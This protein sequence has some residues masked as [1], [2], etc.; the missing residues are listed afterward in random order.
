MPPQL[1]SVRAGAIARQLARSA[2]PV[3]GGAP[4]SS[5]AQ[6]CAN[7]P[8]AAINATIAAMVAYSA[9]HPNPPLPIAFHY[10]LDPNCCVFTIGDDDTANPLRLCS[11]DLGIV[12]MTASDAPVVLDLIVQT[13]RANG[14]AAAT[15]N[16]TA[17]CAPIG[18][19]DCTKNP[20]DP[21][22]PPDCKTH[23]E[24]PRCPPTTTTCPQPC[25]PPCIEV[26]VPP[27]PPCPPLNIPPCVQIDLCDWEKFCAKI[28]E[29]LIKA[30]EDCALDNDVAYSFKDCDGSFGQAIDL[31]YGEQL[32]DVATPD[33]FESIMASASAKVGN[34]SDGDFA[35][36]DPF[37]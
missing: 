23:P 11:I 6:P 21:S 13:L 2:G 12:T 1:A 20:L 4:V 37:L 16:C 15:G 25:N 9:A 3:A 34:F 28:K 29:C 22:C 31:W 14:V 5:F 30:K 17:S 18:G 32:A 24:D 35:P 19:V 10:Y 26:N 7:P 33:S 27:C 8:D 36:A